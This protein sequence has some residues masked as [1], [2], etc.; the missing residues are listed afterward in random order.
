MQAR[1]RSVG[2][3]LT[4]GSQ[5][6][7]GLDLEGA[8]DAGRGAR[9]RGA[10]ADAERRGRD[11]GDQGLVRGR[12]AARDRVKR[13]PKASQTLGVAMASGGRLAEERL[14]AF[15]M[16]RGR[17]APAAGGSEKR[18]PTAHLVA[19]LRLA[20]CTCTAPGST[21]TLHGD[22]NA[23]FLHTH[24][25]PPGRPADSRPCGRSGG[26]GLGGLDTPPA[27]DLP[28][29]GWCCHVSRRWSCPRAATTTFTLDL[30]QA[31]SGAGLHRSPRT[32][33][34]GG[35]DHQPSRRCFHNS[36]TASHAYICPYVHAMHAVVD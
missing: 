21:C 27:Q 15:H 11:A 25:H 16:D 20:T 13:Q 18:K 26:P 32:A 19:A 35:A 17:R 12:H 3:A 36:V 31:A 23:V 2:M 28:T 33:C 14:G 6:W 9:A 10:D 7:D 5:G 4:T 29:R 1:G 24:T 8:R 34:G 30:D 22:K